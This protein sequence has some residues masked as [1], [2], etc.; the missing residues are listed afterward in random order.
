MSITLFDL[1]KRRTSLRLFK[2]DPVLCHSAQHILNGHFLPNNL[3]YSCAR[4]D[5]GFRFEANILRIVTPPAVEGTTFNE[6]GRAD[7]WAVVE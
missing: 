1:A 7:T 2:K 6:Y 3:T 4:A 5:H